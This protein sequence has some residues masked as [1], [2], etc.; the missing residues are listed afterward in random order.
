AEK[1]Q[2][3]II[4]WLLDALL[5]HASSNLA[6]ASESA[7]DATDAPENHG[8]SSLLLRQLRWLEVVVDPDQLAEKLSETLQMAPAN[9]QRDIIVSLPE[10]LGD[11][12]PESLLEELLRIVNEHTSLTTAAVDALSELRI[13]GA[14]QERLQRDVCA[15]LRYAHGD[16]LPVLLRFLLSTASADNATEVVQLVRKSLDLR[17]IARISKSKHG[18]TPETVLVDMLRSCLQ[19]YSYLADA[20]LQV[21]LQATEREEPM[22]LDIVV[23]YLLQPKARKKVEAL[24]RR[25]IGSGR[26]SASLF[27]ECI[28]NHGEALRGSFADMLLMAEVLLRKPALTQSGKIADASMAMYVA[29]FRVADPYHRQEVIVSLVTHVGSGIISFQIALFLSLLLLSAVKP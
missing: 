6:S 22:I 13:P 25:H 18:D 28:T 7:N 23:C 20:W 11:M 15:L 14:A 17:Q 8:S 21:L 9:V 19:R 24:T 3:Q 27:T 5:M 12:L 1:L 10:I 16:E 4:D 29:L 2:P 26:F